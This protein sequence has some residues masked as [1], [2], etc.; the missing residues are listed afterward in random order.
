VETHH[1]E[2]KVIDAS[3][4]RELQETISAATIALEISSLN[5]RV[6]ALQ[7]AGNGGASAST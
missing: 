3:R 5:V 2:R 6:A 7:N 4:V 1:E